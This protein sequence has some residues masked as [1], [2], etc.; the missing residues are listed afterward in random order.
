MVLANLF[1]VGKAVQRHKA[2]LVTGNA[3]IIGWRSFDLRTGFYDSESRTRKNFTIRYFLKNHPRWQKFNLPDNDDLVQVQGRLVGRFKHKDTRFQYLCCRIEDFSVFGSHP[4][5]EK[6]TIQG[7]IKDDNQLTKKGITTD[8]TQTLQSRSWTARSK[9]RILQQS[10]EIKLATLNDITSS[11]QSYPNS[12]I[13]SSHSNLNHSPLSKRSHTEAFSSTDDN[14]LYSPPHSSCN[15]P[16]VPTP[17]PFSQS[18]SPMPSLR[19]EVISDNEYIPSTQP[20]PADEPP[21]RSA[22]ARKPNSKFVD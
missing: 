13:L 10:P 2:S 7:R 19:A 14:D 20:P 11:S 21:R 12:P 15:N 1:I 5:L 18:E 9:S 8:S 3:E 6:S 16:Q 17:I 22:R 4:K